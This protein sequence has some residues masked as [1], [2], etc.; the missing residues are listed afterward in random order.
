V[1]FFDVA[2]HDQVV[3]L[4]PEINIRCRTVKEFFDSLSDAMKIYS[5]S[6]NDEKSKVLKN[7]ETGEQFYDTYE[8]EI[9]PEIASAVVISPDNT[10]A[11]V[12]SAMLAGQ[13]GDFG[14]LFEQALRNQEAVPLT[15]NIFRVPNGSNIMDIADL[16]LR[17]SSYI[18][19]QQ[20]DPAKVKDV[21][22]TPV[23]RDRDAKLKKLIADIQ[24]PLKWYRVR[25]VVGLKSYSQNSGQYARKITYQIRKYDIRNGKDMNYY[26]WGEAPPVKKY[27]Y[28]FTGK[29]EDVLDFKV[30]FDTLY[31]LIAL[32]SLGKNQTVSGSGA[33]EAT[34]DSLAKLAEESPGIPAAFSGSQRERSTFPITTSPASVNAGTNLYGGSGRAQIQKSLELSTNLISSAGGDNVSIDLEILGDPE[35]LVGYNEKDFLT[36]NQRVLDS[37]S[38]NNNS[39]NTYERNPEEDMP[40]LS[41]L[42]S[43]VN[44]LISFRSPQDYDPETG[45]MMTESDPKYIDGIFN[46]IYKVMSVRSTFING[47]FRQSLNCVRLPNQTRDY[48][49]YKSEMKIINDPNRAPSRTNSEIQDSGRSKPGPS[50]WIVG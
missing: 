7:N 2:L 50:D 18:T 5:K 14:V 46:G 32:D 48:D 17:T 23:G 12:R 35:F 15:T 33:A 1:P 25:P 36:A 47:V 44:C 28:I 29:N 41:S 49:Y 27:E 43:E 20:I 45:M 21:F 38:I 8:F 22:D 19:G 13:I 26:G 3:N 16:I 6:Q 11:A 34:T 39:N 31:Y 37:I 42:D 10:D 24:Q 40:N 30:N 4:K 9:D